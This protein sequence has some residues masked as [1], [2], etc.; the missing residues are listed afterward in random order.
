MKY[1][2]I[3]LLLL[4]TFLLTS[5]KEKIQKIEGNNTEVET[6]KMELEEVSQELEEMEKINQEITENNKDIVNY[7]N[8]EE[9]TMDEVSGYYRVHAPN[10]IG[11]Y[12]SGDI[13]VRTVVLSP[14]VYPITAYEFI[15][16]KLIIDLLDI[17]LESEYIRK[18]TDVFNVYAVSKGVFYIKES[19]IPTQE[20]AKFHYEEKQLLDVIDNKIDY[21][22]YNQKYFEWERET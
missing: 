5:C 8:V 19:L 7:R 9:Y 10:E 13:L 3:V 18:K 17:D 11:I 12:I 2:Q 20:N 22:Y 6:L 21:D 14:T 1:K 4:S 16:N 15:G